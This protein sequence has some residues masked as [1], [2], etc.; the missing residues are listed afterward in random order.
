VPLFPEIDLSGLGIG[1]NGQNPALP[2]SAPVGVQAGLNQSLLALLANFSPGDLGVCVVDERMGL[3]LPIPDWASWSW[4]EQGT[5][6]NSAAT[7]TDPLTIF[8]VPPDERAEIKALYVRRAS[9]DNTVKSLDIVLP[10]GYSSGT[11]IFRLIEVATAVAAGFVYWPDPGVQQPA[12]IDSIFP[13]KL[14]PNSTVTITPDGD[15]VAITTWDYSI[16]L[17]RTKIVRALLP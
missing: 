1:L 4:I 15:G 3:N 8:T 2:A 11:G 12:N 6:G 14:E 10:A 13:L 7:T 17:E 16:A 5:S 9:G